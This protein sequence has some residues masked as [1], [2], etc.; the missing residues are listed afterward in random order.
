MKLD[1]HT[2]QSASGEYSRKVWLL[3][4]DQNAVTKL[5]VILDAEIYLEKIGAAETVSSLQDENQIPP[6]TCV[7]VSNSDAEKRH[8]DYTCNERY[9]DFIANDLMDWVGKRVPSVSESGNII[10]G[11]SLSGLASAYI[12]MAYPDRFS[13]AVCQSGS[14]WWENEWLKDNLGKNTDGKYWISVG[15]RETGFGKS[16]PPT[17]LRQDVSQIDAAKNFSEA[18]RNQGNEVQFETFEG[19]HETKAWRRELP[20][21]FGWLI[22]KS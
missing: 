1:E 20:R 13:F 10:C 12:R 9:A 5:C 17:G 15:D 18:L 22:G 2:L 14:F 11:L 8:Y 16:H 6:V 21:A 7:F 3:N 4:G 19:G